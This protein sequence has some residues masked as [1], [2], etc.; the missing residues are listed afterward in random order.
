[1]RIINL[2]SDKILK[3]SL[4]FILSLIFC[5]SLS[6]QSITWQRLFNYAAVIQ[7]IQQTSDGGYIAVGNVGINFSEKMILFKLDQKGDTSW[8]KIIGVGNTQGYWVEECPDKGFIIGGSIDSGFV[9]DKVYLV[10][11]DSQ[12]N[13]QWHKTYMNSELDQ[14]LCVKQTADGGYILSC[15][16]TPANSVKT[17]FIGTDSVGNLLWKKI[18]GDGIN[19]LSIAEIA[20]CPSGFLVIGGIGLQQFADV[21]LAKLNLYGDTLWTK[22][23]GGNNLDFGSSIDKINN[24]GYII[25]GD[26]RSFNINGKTESYIIKIDT[27]GETLWEKTYSNMGY[28]TCRSIKYKPNS[29][30]ALCGSSDSTGL[31]NFNEAKFRFV[32]LNG[33]PI[34]ENS[35]YPGQDENAFFSIDLTNDGGFVMG[36][37]ANLIPGGTHLFAVKTDSSGRANLIGIIDPV[38]IHPNKF[39]LYQNYPNPFNSATIIKYELKENADVELSICD[40]LGKQISII[41]KGKKDIGTYSF[42]FNADDFHMT[43]GIYFLIIKIEDKSSNEVTF[44]K[45]IIYLK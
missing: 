29:G 26:S 4:I 18:Y 32:D 38:E 35:F 43:S 21:Y 5:Q 23:K 37:Y 2:K 17:M 11:T 20:L 8:L 24:G 6:S 12:G 3:L 7:R 27:N 40:I 28:E 1:M 25:G 45:K 10:R 19:S 31:S 36:G 9:D 33:N 13:I 39:F 16:T 41:N 42:R 22:R 15:R 44:T 30:F 34:L 14:C